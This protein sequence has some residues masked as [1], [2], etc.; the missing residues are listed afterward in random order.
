MQGGDCFISCSFFCSNLSTFIPVF[1]LSSYFTSYIFNH[2]FSSFIP[3]PPF[4]LC[5]LCFFF[6][7]PLQQVHRVFWTYISILAMPNTPG[8]T[9][10]ATC[11]MLVELWNPSV[12]PPVGALTQVD[13]RY[14]ICTNCWERFSFYLDLKISSCCPACVCGIWLQVRCLACVRAASQS[15]GQ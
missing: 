2:I 8:W 11:I 12:H 4:L 7:F 1:P 6:H 10:A 15:A 5:S 3:Y 14:S 9:S 13:A